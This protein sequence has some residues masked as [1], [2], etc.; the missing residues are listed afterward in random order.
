M[1]AFSLGSIV[2]DLRKNERSVEKAKLALDNKE[3]ANEMDKPML[4]NRNKSPDNLQ[5]KFELNSASGEKID[6]KNRLDN[7]NFG[8]K[9]NTGKTNPVEIFDENYQKVKGKQNIDI[10]LK[11]HEKSKLIKETSDKT[12]SNKDNKQQ[13]QVNVSTNKEN[14]EKSSNQTFLT[15]EERNKHKDSSFTADNT[16][17]RDNN[18]SSSQTKS[19]E[20]SKKTRWDIVMKD[21]DHDTKNRVSRKRKDSESDSDARSSRKGSPPVMYV[22]GKKSKVKQSSSGKKSSTPS[23]KTTAKSRKASP[24]PSKQKSVYDFGLLLRKEWEFKIPKKSTNAKDDKKF[25]GKLS[26]T[27]REESKLS[28]SPSIYNGKENGY[29]SNT[30]AGRDSNKKSEKEKHSSRKSGYIGEKETFRLFGKEENKDSKGFKEKRKPCKSTVVHTTVPR[31]KDVGSIMQMIRNNVLSKDN[32]KNIDDFTDYSPSDSLTDNQSQVASEDTAQ[33]LMDIM[34]GKV[35]LEIIDEVGADTDSM[36]D[37][38]SFNISN[39]YAKDLNCAIP[40]VYGS[41]TNHLS[42]DV[43]KSISNVDVTNITDT[44]NDRKKDSPLIYQLENT[45]MRDLNDNLVTSAGQNLNAGTLPEKSTNGNLNSFPVSTSA[46]KRPVCVI[47]PL[48]DLDFF[49]P[50]VDRKVEEVNHG[51]QMRITVK[52]DCPLN[53]TVIGYSLVELIR[54]C[55]HGKQEDMRIVTLQESIVQRSVSLTLHKLNIAA[56]LERT[57]DK[58]D[59]APMIEMEPSTAVK[60]KEEIIPGLGDLHV[61]EEAI[62]TSFNE[63]DTEN[64]EVKTKTTEVLKCDQGVVNEAKNLLQSAKKDDTVKNIEISPIR[65]PVSKKAVPE[66]KR[67]YKEQSKENSNRGPIR[68]TVSKVHRQDRQHH[69]YSRKEKHYKCGWSFDISY[70]LQDIMENLTTS[71]YKDRKNMSTPNSRRPRFSNYRFRRSEVPEFLPDEREDNYL[72]EEAIPDFVERKKKAEMLDNMSTVGGEDE[73]F[74][75]EQTMYDRETEPPREPHREHQREDSRTRK[76]RYFKR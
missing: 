15:S 49:V 26:S 62:H 67:T 74:S 50:S 1:V 34:D 72:T 5:K 36:L 24:S 17:E 53:K 2:S 52:N 14:K 63:E 65:G 69:P 44:H 48:D 32:K 25:S 55:L 68:S 75:V 16:H 8:R 42:G 22:S 73:P 37:I 59:A 13:G 45:H 11:M 31:S 66:P 57:V 39:D 18:K 35:P 23:K 20:L 43:H 41:K 71:S 3:I 76:A 51:K 9:E 10:K 56:T 61:L 21:L 19:E 70:T 12:S 30:E 7:T 40:G 28:K 38:S 6:D 58:K 27:K 54:T 64:D 4:K 29:I 47:D 60:D 46:T 33:D